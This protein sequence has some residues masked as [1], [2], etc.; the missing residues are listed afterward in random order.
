VVGWEKENAVFCYIVRRQLSARAV[1][2]FHHTVY[3]DE[4]SDVETLDEFRVHEDSADCG[5]DS[6]KA[7][8]LLGT[9]DE[10]EVEAV[11]ERPEIVAKSFK[12]WRMEREV[13]VPKSQPVVDEG[14]CDSRAALSA[15]NQRRRDAHAWVVLVM[16]RRRRIA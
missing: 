9:P 13:S 8:Q 16:R 10:L 7:P 15:E 14:P 3:R 2:S 6:P 4:V 1:S 5:R 12:L 11:A